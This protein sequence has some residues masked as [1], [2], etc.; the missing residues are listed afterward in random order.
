MKAS[1]V[2]NRTTMQSS[3]LL[4]AQTNRHEWKVRSHSP[5]ETEEIGKAIGHVLEGGEIVA[6]YGDFG[7]GKTALVRGLAMGLN[8]PCGTVASPTFVFIHHYH[9]RLSLIH[10][11]LYRLESVSDLHHLGLTD[12]LDGH[13]VVAIEWAEKADSELP[14]DCLEIRVGHAGKNARDI[15]LRA[16]GPASSSVLRRMKKLPSRRKNHDFGHPPNS[17]P[18]TF[19]RSTKKS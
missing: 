10:V 15:Y 9:G 4:M 18:T 14:Q 6:L 2:T 5:S 12:F 17:L 7:A 16:N 1:K 8:V 3:N 11:D 13:S 19:H